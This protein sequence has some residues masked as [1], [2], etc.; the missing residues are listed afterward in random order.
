MSLC[1]TPPGTPFDVEY[2]LVTSDNCNPLVEYDWRDASPGAA[3]SPLGDSGNLPVPLPFT[4]NFGGQDYSSIRIH[5]NGFISLGNKNADTPDGNFRS[6]ALLP[7]TLK[8]DNFI[9]PF[10]DDLTDN[11]GTGRVYT[12]TLGAPPNREFVIEYRGVGRAGPPANLNF[13]VV[14]FET[15][16]NVEIQYRSL[17]GSY[18]DGSSATVGLEYGNIIGGFAAYE[19]SHNLPGALENGLALLFIPYAGGAPTLPSHAVCP[20]MKAVTIESGVASACAASSGAFDVDIEAGDL[21][22]RSPLKVQ[23]VFTAPVMPAAFVDLQHY[24]DIRLSYSPPLSTLSLPPVEV[25]YEYT[26]QDLLAAGGHPENLFIAAHERYSNQWQ[27]L[28]TRVDLPN[29]RLFARA[30][31]FSYYGVATLDPSGGTSGRDLDG[32]GLPVTGGPF[33]RELA[34]LLFLFGGLLFVTGGL[35]I[36]IRRR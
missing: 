2:D 34:A 31:H 29:S 36:K 27:R 15:S 33:S 25:C 5:A 26:P 4:F 8:P 28:P 24:A 21:L 16:N 6:N 7:T 17:S 9:A 22:H 13:E 35:W 30:P 1:S 11:G 23:Q 14:L 20:Q 3:L 10:W 12:A 18:A 32:L 19:Y